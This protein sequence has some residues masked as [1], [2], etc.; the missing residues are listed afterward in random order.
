MLKS[1]NECI[2]KMKMYYKI[3]KMRMY[4]KIRKKGTFS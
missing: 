4:Y 1:E 3:R 2:I